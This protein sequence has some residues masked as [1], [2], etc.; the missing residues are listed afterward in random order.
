MIF[1]D[2]S[3]CTLSV[4]VCMRDWTP[5]ARQSAAD[6]NPSSGPKC[7]TYTCITQQ[8]HS[9]D[10]AVHLYPAWLLTPVHNRVAEWLQTHIRSSLLRCTV[11]PCVPWLADLIC[12]TT[13]GQPQ[14]A[15]GPTTACTHHAVDGRV[16]SPITTLTVG[17]PHTVQDTS[18]GWMYVGIRRKWSGRKSAGLLRF[19]HKCSGGCWMA[20]RPPLSERSP[21]PRCCASYRQMISLLTHC[22]R[23]LLPAKLLRE[24]V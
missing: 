12:Q 13:P 9:T 2:Q 4:H 8:T 15:P 21:P 11:T 14:L 19:L 16:W 20:T 1:I 23:V 6:I 24:N 18:T 10:T 3:I 22:S 17:Y 5:R 7:C